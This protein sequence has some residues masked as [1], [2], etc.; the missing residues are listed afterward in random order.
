MTNQ[1]MITSGTNFGISISQFDRDIP[2]KLVFESHGLDTGDGFD[3]R[4]FTVGDVP[5]GP[6]TRSM[7]H[8]H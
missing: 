5:D 2:H 3:D 1:D 7:S 4:G 8:K 6:Y